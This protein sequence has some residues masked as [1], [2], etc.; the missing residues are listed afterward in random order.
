MINV[1]IKLIKI[2]QISYQKP[3]GLD[4]NL[5]IMIDKL[6]NLK[7][8]RL[9]LK[10]FQTI[11]NIYMKRLSRIINKIKN[12]LIDKLTIKK[13]FNHYNFQISMQIKSLIN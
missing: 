10:N 6:K 8:L 2:N 7:K 5:Y 11:I 9:N 1:R 4:H 3:L 13:I 12:S